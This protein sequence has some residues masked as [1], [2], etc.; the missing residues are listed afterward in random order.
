MSWEI[1]SPDLRVCCKIDPASAQLQQSKVVVELPVV[2]ARVPDDSRNAE[3]H[4]VGF[5]VRLEVVISQ[6]YAEIAQ[7]PLQPSPIGTPITRPGGQLALY[8]I[9]SF[10]KM[11][12][13]QSAIEI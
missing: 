5:V 13:Q 10:Q 11:E 7:G 9:N 1:R 3:R 12:S 8:G 2:V 4:L 6:N